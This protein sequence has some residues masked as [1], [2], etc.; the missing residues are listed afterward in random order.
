MN[1]RKRRRQGVMP[2]YGTGW[3][4]GKTPEGHNGPSYTGYNNNNTTTTAPPQY[5]A[6]QNPQYT[7]QNFN[8]N[9]GYYG[10]QN[11]IELQQPSATYA[12]NGGYAA[13]AGPP[14]VKQHY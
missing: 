14:P 3:L 7:G 12:G 6:P 1:A 4:A 8:S 2:M 5:S 10:Q 13:P 9:E 11:G